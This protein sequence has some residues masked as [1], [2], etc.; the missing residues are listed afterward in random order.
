LFAHEEDL[1]AKQKRTLST[2][3]RVD[4]NIFRDI[5][6]LKSSVPSDEAIAVELRNQDVKIMRLKSAVYWIDYVVVTPTEPEW[7]KKQQAILSNENCMDALLKAGMDFL[8]VNDLAAVNR[9]NED[10]AVLH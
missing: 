5:T 3:T 2:M 4:T 8:D 6:A 9:I 1:N 10:N 7:H